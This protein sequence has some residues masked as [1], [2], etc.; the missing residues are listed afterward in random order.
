[1]ALANAKSFSV[2]MSSNRVASRVSELMPHERKNGKSEEINSNPITISR[3]AA[4]S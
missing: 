4:N 3:S 2:A 1:M